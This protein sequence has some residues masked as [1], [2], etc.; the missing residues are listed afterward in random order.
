MRLESRRVSL[1]LVCVGGEVFWLEGDMVLEGE[2]R[3][4][5]LEGG[6]QAGGSVRGVGGSGWLCR[7]SEGRRR[8]WR[9]KLAREEGLTAF[10]GVAKSVSLACLE[11]W[12]LRKIPRLICS[13]FA[14]THDE[15]DF[16]NKSLF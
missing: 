1:G 8:C 7:Y 4:G 14:I 2:G 3:E 16:H 11:F 6:C 12:S 15:Q 9:H 13:L 5:V 10:N